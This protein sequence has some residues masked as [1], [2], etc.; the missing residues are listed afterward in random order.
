M[1]DKKIRIRR[2]DCYKMLND[3][4]TI[5]NENQ[6]DYQACYWKVEEVITR[7]ER[8]HTK[9]GQNHLFKR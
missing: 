5:I 7:F 3:I 2:K 8:M 4:R 6:S 9:R 1:R